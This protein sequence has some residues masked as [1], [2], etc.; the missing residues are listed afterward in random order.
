MGYRSDL[1]IVHSFTERSHMEE[2]LTAFILDKRCSQYNLTDYLNVS[3]DKSHTKEGERDV[4]SLVFV[5]EQWKWYEES[6]LGGYEDVKCINSMLKLC[7][8][9]HKERGIPYAYKFLRVGE[10]MEDIEQREYTSECK[11]GEFLEDYQE[12]SSYIQT[13]IEKDFANL[14][15]VSATLTISEEENYNE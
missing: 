9:F 3:V 7:E 8:A 4:Y 14:K 15:P 11:D 5:G 10:E 1:V 2:V 6:P 13:S 12:S